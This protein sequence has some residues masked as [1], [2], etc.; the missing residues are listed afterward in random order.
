V[1]IAVA[2]TRTPSRWNSPLIR[3]RPPAGVLLG[4]ADDQLLEVVV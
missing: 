4:E 3:W 1:R 2:E